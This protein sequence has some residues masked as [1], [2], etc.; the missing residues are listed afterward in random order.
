MTTVNHDKTASSTSN[1][2][3]QLPASEKQLKFARHLS[4]KNGVMLP[5]EVQSDRRSL[6]Q[7]IN[8]Q[9][10]AQRQTNR[11]DSYPSSKQVQFAE[12]IARYKRSQ[13]PDECF[14]DK[15]LMSRWIDCNK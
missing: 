10:G 15:Q 8:E 13:V 9:K 14:R 4:V 5:W 2:Y 12:R 3:H 11:F 1:D 7:W 6:S